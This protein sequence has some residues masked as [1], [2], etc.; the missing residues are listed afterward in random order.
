MEGGKSMIPCVGWIP[1]GEQPLL[2]GET[3][4]TAAS[5]LRQKNPDHK[6][7]SREADAVKTQ[8]RRIH[9]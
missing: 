7:R 3:F 5:R 9:G 2:K 8:R 4:L 1:K 6:P